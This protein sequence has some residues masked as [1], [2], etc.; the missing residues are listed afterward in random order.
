VS[1]DSNII[2][3]AN[4]KFIEPTLVTIP[5]VESG[6]YE[7]MLVK[8]ED[9]QFSKADLDKT[10]AD[11]SQSG[12]R[13]LEDCNDNSVIVRTSNY[14]NF[15]YDTIAQGKGD[16][17]AIASVFNS[18]WQLTIRTTQ[19]VNLTGER[20]DGGGG[21]PI[22]PVDEINEGFD[23]A[24]DYTDIALDGWLNVNIVGDRRWQG[25]TYQ[26]EKYAQA[27]GYNSG[28]AELESWL[29]TPPVTMNEDKVLTFLSAKAY[30][31]HAGNNGLTVWASTDFDGT[32]VNAANWT[33]L[34]AN[35]ASSSDPDNDWIESGA[36]SLSQFNQNTFIGFKYVGSETESTSFRLDDIVVTAGGGGNNG[37]TSINEDFEG[38]TDYEDIN[39]LGW[40]N[41]ALVGSRAWQGKE[42]DA[43]L[44]AQATSYNS[45]EENV[46]WLITVKIDLDAMSSPKLVFETAQAYWAH[47]GLTVYISTD[48]NGSNI[49]SAT[50][51][52]L[53]CNLAGQ[54]DPDHEWVSS[55]IVDLSSYSGSGYI[56]YK[57]EGNGNGAST[58]S[59]RID[60]IVLYD[61]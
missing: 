19:E 7:S 23:D 16:F 47:D 31:A 40:D 4:G 37:V 20:C 29:I 10:Y 36:I 51:E 60:N 44:Y 58:T 26:S 39:I 59:Y 6:D 41:E 38:Q 57:Y 30:W 54:S 1:N 45:G 27:T 28:A 33:Q 25:K 49:E 55:G 9:V 22:D 14:A 21:G 11:E 17:T 48:Y 50:W 34:D 13:I 12:N 35:V 56:G 43:N 46:C 18:D 53:D 24:E 42:F 8:L 52:V 61:E 2:I 3:I 15:A 32:N 5:E